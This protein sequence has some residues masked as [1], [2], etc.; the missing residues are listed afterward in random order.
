MSSTNW[1]EVDKEG[2]AKLI[3]G[4][5]KVFIIHELFQNAA[6]E[7]V[8]YVRINAEML[9]RRPVARIRVED[10]APD[11]FKHLS[12]A[13][14][15]FAESYKKG[16]PEK[17]GRFNLGEKLVLSQCIEAKIST[18]TGTVVFN[19]DGRT[20]LK[21]KTEKGTVF[22]AL[23]RMTRD[24]FDLLCKDVRKLIVPSQINI[25]FNNEKPPLHKLVKT[26]EVTL[27]TVISDNE[28]NLRPTKRKTKVEL[29]ETNPGEVGT[30]YELGIPVVD[31]FDKWHYNVKQRVPLNMERDNVTPAY[32]RE[33]RKAV[34]NEMVGFLVSDDADDEW[35]IDAAGAIGVTKEAAKCVIKLQFGDKYAAADPT[36]RESQE[37]ATTNGY[38]VIPSRGLSRD[39]RDRLKEFDLL[40]SSSKLFPTPQAFSDDPDALPAEFLEREDWTEDLIFFEKYIRALAIK[41]IDTDI[42]V[43][44]VKEMGVR[45]CF[46]NNIVTFNLKRLGKDWFKNPIREE[47]HELLIHEL[48]H[49]YCSSHHHEDYYK[50]VQKIGAKLSIL[51]LNLDKVL[52]EGVGN[53][54]WKIIRQNSL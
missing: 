19:S 14:T 52:E 37:K 42:T 46:G 4:K 39:Q 21:Q 54:S 47:V 35:V 11:G 8:S 26:I 30:I 5:P 27:P 18:T 45:A 41:L 48:A 17:A 6:D 44:Y 53:A 25:S 33:L 24:E 22:D 13:W 23:V 16:N 51:C 7:G 49:H 31:T 50:A 36:D 34:L 12:H 15:M 40:P 10:D 20:Q 28:G 2:L 43:R 9:P 3:A 1:I 32:K 29:Y 38:N